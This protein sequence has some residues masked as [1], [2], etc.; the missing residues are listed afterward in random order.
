MPAGEDDDLFGGRAVVFWLETGRE[1]GGVVVPRLVALGHALSVLARLNGVIYEEEV[2][3]ATRGRTAD[4]DRE[5]C[6]SDLGT[7]YVGG[8]ALRGEGEVGEGLGPV[9][10]LYDRSA[11]SSEVRGQLRVVGTGHDEA[12]RVAGHEVG[13]KEDRAEC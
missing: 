3:G 7:P 5:V 6:P 10:L 4:T 8:S 2:G 11:L 1:G 9:L 12:V 13:G